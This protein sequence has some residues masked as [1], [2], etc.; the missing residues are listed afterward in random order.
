[1][2]CGGKKSQE[3]SSVFGILSLVMAQIRLKLNCR[4]THVLHCIKLVCVIKNFLYVLANLKA[5]FICLAVTSELVSL[6]KPQTLLV[7]HSSY[8]NIAV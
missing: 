1:M 5:R 2:L 3:N 4:D 7:V 8:F 6:L